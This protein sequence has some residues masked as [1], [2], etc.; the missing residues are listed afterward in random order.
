MKRVYL[1]LAWTFAAIN[2]WAQVSPEDY[3]LA[4]QLRQTN[5][6]KKLYNQWVQPEWQVNGGTFVYQVQTRNG[7]EYYQVN[8]EKQEQQIIFNRQRLAALLQKNLHGEV[9]SLNLPISNVALCGNDSI[10]F[11][12]DSLHWTYCVLKNELAKKEP[13]SKP[14]LTEL[15]SPNGM[16]IAFIKDGNIYL[17][18]KST[19]KEWQLSTNGTPENG[20][21]YSLNWDATRNDSRGEKSSYEIEA[22]W[23]PDSKKLIVPRED[24]RRTRRLQLY[25]IDVDGPQSEIVSYERQLAGDTSLT[26][27]TFYLV[28]VA[29]KTITP[30]DLPPN[31]AFLGTGFYMFKGCPKAYHVRYYRGYKKRELFEFDLQTGKTRSILTESYLKTFVDLNV[32]TLNVLYS[33][34]EFIWQSEQ[35]GWS[36][37]YLYNLD[38]GE[39]TNQITKGDFYVYNLVQLDEKR[40]RIWFTA[41]GVDKQIDPYLK[42]LYSIGLNGKGMRCVTPEIAMHDVSISPNGK[43]FVDNYSTYA[44]P[45]VS[46]LRRLSDGKTLMTLE[47]MDIE[48]LKQMGWKPAEP[49]TIAVD[50]GKT[51]L[52][53]LIYK[54]WNFD[55]TEKYPVIDA[56]YTG[57]HT[58]RTPKTFSRAVL[59]MDIS[60]ANLGFVVVTIDGRGCAFRSKQ[61][62]DISYGRLG[63]GL[64]DHVL[65]IKELEKRFSYIDTA[66][67]GIY[68]HSAGGYD[69]ARALL[70]YPNFYKVGVAS[71]GDHDHRMEKI[72]WPEL[73]QGYPVDTA[74][75][76]Q[77][78]I[79]NA[80]KLKGHL[81]LVTG[82]MDN[83][84]NPSATLKLEEALVKANK[85]FKLIILPN[86]DHSSCYWNPYLI[87]KRWEFF[88]TYLKGN[89]QYP[90]TKFSAL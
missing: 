65:A 63:Y 79:T 62:H 24:R 7:K 90:N 68:G 87:R 16:W 60:L 44:T 34:R 10:S 12:T 83:N 77:S 56:T 21:G 49:F 52:Y 46:V 67:V 37:L 80:P 71:S 20:Y 70:L 84:V 64:T 75:Q 25:R 1:C 61:F 4:E 41:G 42:Q 66:R 35:D 36:Q 3:K 26:M 54:P 39:M 17:R 30:I 55:P 59:N 13:I 40:Q 76:N 19:G 73:Y 6:S 23:S 69:A 81:M 47:K 5:L 28:D 38:S 22:Y 48:D 51:M 74:Y 89:K 72:W 29:S 32:E 57:P 85:D 8:S 53:G 2:V 86:N 31:P 45:N 58:I 43:F 33:K 88:M 15:T 11:T 27:A 82:D 78:N 14:N 50:S 9:D 18:E